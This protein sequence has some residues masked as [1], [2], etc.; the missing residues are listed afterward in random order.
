M[1]DEFLTA[2]TFRPVTLEMVYEGPSAPFEGFEMP[3]P[4]LALQ[5][6]LKNQARYNF[7]GLTLYGG[8]VYDQY[9]G[10]RPKDFDI[11][12]SCPEFVDTIQ[13]LLS[14]PRES[15]RDM[16]DENEVM[17]SLVGMFGLQ[18]DDG[19][20]SLRRIRLQNKFDNVSVSGDFYHG[21]DV[22]R[23]DIRV[24]RAEMAPQFISSITA[25]PAVSAVAQINDGQI[26]FAYHKDMMSHLNRKILISR[27]P[28]DEAQLAYL[29]V[30]AKSKGF[31]V[32][33]SWNNSG[34]THAL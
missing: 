19:A 28:R 17:A 31:Q 1:Q 21:N 4:V 16:H 6:H 8:A 9:L 3:A 27:N 33:K 11:F 30:L 12:V 7:Q 14:K 29:L 15:Y 34:P 25:S 10:R 5:E 20:A 32:I 22:F 2:S 23:M 18:E 13:S 26:K 24:G